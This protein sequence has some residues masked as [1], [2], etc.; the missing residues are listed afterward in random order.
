MIVSTEFGIQVLIL[1]L[2]QSSNL[3]QIARKQPMYVRQGFSLGC[4][5]LLFVGR[6]IV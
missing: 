6:D 3:F 5:E 2:C 4:E 1:F